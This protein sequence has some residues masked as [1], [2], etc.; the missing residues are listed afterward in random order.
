M[1][2]LT[3]PVTYLRETLPDEH[4][5]VSSVVF[6]GRA[7]IL[8]SWLVSQPPHIRLHLILVCPAS[9]FAPLRVHT[10][11]HHSVSLWMKLSSFLL[12][13]LSSFILARGQ[14]HALPRRM[15]TRT[16]LSVSA[17]FSPS[18]GA[19]GRRRLEE[20]VRLLPSMSVS[21]LASL[22]AVSH[23][24]MCCCCCSTADVHAP[25]FWVHCG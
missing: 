2:S 19:A 14:L 10:F 25:H 6:L 18:A 3:K 7:F 20:R 9:G 11:L 17:R 4:N 15:M 16:E 5:D 1:F 24:G 12:Y 21:M 22:A 13:S 23:T 8:K